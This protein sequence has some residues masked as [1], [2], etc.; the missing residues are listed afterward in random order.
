MS[1]I[2]CSRMSACCKSDC[3]VV[4][5]EWYDL[6]LFV[7]SINAGEVASVP[8]VVTRQPMSKLQT[9]CQMKSVMTQLNSRCSNE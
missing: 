2:V 5:V 6:Q 3:V 4:S 7:K 9:M 1:A 8:V